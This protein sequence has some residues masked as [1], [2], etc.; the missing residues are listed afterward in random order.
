[1]T[2]ISNKKIS[3]R[4]RLINLTTVFL[5]LVVGMLVFILLPTINAITNLQREILTKKIEL[6]ETL[7]KEQNM[8]KLN[9]KIKKIEPKLAEFNSIYIH[10]NEELEFITALEELALANNVKQTLGLL[11]E[12]AAS[13]GEHKKI[14][15]N[16]AA[17][18]NFFNITNYLAELESLD[19]YI[20]VEGFDL[21]SGNKTL[22]GNSLKVATPES[23]PTND[24]VQLNLS[25][26][27]YWK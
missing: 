12:S 26:Y 23:I 10:E 17:V 6:E 16:I 4:K 8:S 2:S 22:S 24:S 14:P 27:S 19:Y 21:S 25:A 15:L 7:V 20:S 18:G 13:E 1:M 3:T 11:T 5:S 9:E